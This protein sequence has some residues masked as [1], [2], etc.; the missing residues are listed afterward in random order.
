MPTP[1][2]CGKKQ[3]SASCFQSELANKETNRKVVFGQTQAILP[4]A[5]KVTQE[6]RGKTRN[7]SGATYTQDGKKIDM[8]AYNQI[9]IY[10][11]VGSKR[12]KKQGNISLVRISNKI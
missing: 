2:N 8:K 11:Q 6:I 5:R 4:Q 7:N 3:R 12:R 10:Q 9:L 1:V